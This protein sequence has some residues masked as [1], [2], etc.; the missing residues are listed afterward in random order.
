M[1]EWENEIDIKRLLD[2]TVRSAPLNL[3]RPE[4]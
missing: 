2:A 4:C 1:E 3:N